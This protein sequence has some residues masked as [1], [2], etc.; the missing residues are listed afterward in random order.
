MAELE[1]RVR[2]VVEAEDAQVQLR[3]L[4][5]KVG[6]AVFIQAEREGEGDRVPPNRLFE[7]RPERVAH[8]DKP[9][10]GV[11]HSFMCMSLSGK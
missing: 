8:G 9:H 3:Q 2:V 10:T 7:D 11:P 1:S 6:L 5:W 4:G